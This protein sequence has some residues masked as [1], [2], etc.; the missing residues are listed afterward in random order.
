MTTSPAARC[1]GGS[2]AH[3]DVALAF[4][5][6][7]E[8]HD[9]LGARLEQR[10]RGVGARRLVAPGRGEARLDED[11]AD[12]ANDAQGFRE[13]VHHVVSD[14]DLRG[15]PAPRSRTAEEIGEQQ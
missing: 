9:A 2:R 11:G 15:P 5:D 12:E 13:R 14:F 1:T 10:R 3:L 6:E 8:D 4:G 7:V